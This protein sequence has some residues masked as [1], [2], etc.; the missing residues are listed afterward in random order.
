MKKTLIIITLL[1]IPV[2]FAFPK[3]L[4]ES[5]VRVGIILNANSINV[6]CEGKYYIYEI[7]TGRK[8]YIE[9]LDDHLMKLSGGRIYFDSKPFNPSIR[10]VSENAAS[11]IRVNGR[12]YKDNLLVTV[13]NSKFNVINELGIQDYL[14]GILPRE[15]NPEWGME[16]LKAQAVISRTYALRNMRR[17]DRDNFDLCTETHCQVYGGIESE[18]ERTNL[19]VEKTRGEVL[20]FEG[21]LAQSLFHAACGG[22]TENPNYVWIWDSKPPKYLE[23]RRDKYCSQSPHNYWKGRIEGAKIKNRLIKAGYK[24]GDIKKI[25]VDGRNRSGRAK[26][27]KIVS[28]AGTLNINAAK[29]RLAVDPWLIKSVLFTDILSYGDSFEFRG[30]GW[31]HGVGMCQWGAK[32]MADK[33]YNYEEI[34]HFYYP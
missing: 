12:R 5:I 14:C 33:N 20:T 19:A 31:G 17:H 23:G 30:R 4:P 18:K 28:S 9:P 32:F 3:R 2:V 16:A 27:L 7:N 11:S 29:F 6:S 34:L 22:Y 15:V 24:L 21:Q 25:S 1:S 13:K 8:T 10:L 26:Y